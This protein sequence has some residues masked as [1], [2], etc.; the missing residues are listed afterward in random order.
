MSLN[1]APRV[2]TGCWARTRHDP[3]EPWA[4]NQLT[5]DVFVRTLTAAL[6]PDEGDRVRAASEAGALD[7]LDAAM[8]SED[9]R[10]ILSLLRVTNVER[11]DVAMDALPASLHEQLAALSPLARIHGLHAPVIVLGHDRD[12][13]VVPV[14]ESRQLA[15]ALTGRAGVRY[16]EFA[17]FQHATPRQ[18]SPAAL[19]RELA[20]F[21]GYV[22]PIFRQAVS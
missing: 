21:L 5:R 11:V 19:V 6:T 1:C 3:R 20:R 15:A 18:L 16:T 12:D 9:A 13:Q 7:G 10:A 8:L 17:F 22:Y 2:G 14:S 4:V